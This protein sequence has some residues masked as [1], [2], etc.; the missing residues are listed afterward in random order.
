ML[1]GFASLVLM[2]FSTIFFPARFAMLHFLSKFSA[3]QPLTNLCCQYALVMLIIRPSQSNFFPTKSASQRLIMRDPLY[4]EDLN[5]YLSDS[6]LS[7]LSAFV[8]TEITIR[9]SLKKLM[10]FWT[11]EDFLQSNLN[12][13]RNSNLI[14]RASMN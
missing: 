1:A 13:Y 10:V 8:V 12:N 5:A 14:R 7:V 6:K 4:S 9:L 11:R 2:A 3:S